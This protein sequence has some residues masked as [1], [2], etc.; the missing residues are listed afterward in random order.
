MLCIYHKNCAD[1]FGAAWAV[2]QAIS[3]AEF[4]AASHGTEPPDVTD[5]EVL[6][7]DFCYKRNVILEMAKK[8]KSITI[9]DHH[10]SAMNELIDLPENVIT[11]FDMEHSGAMLAWNFFFP[12]KEPPMLLRHIEDRDLWKFSLPNTKEI[13]TA[14]FAY[15]YD[16]DEWDIL[17]RR[18]LD[19]LVHEGIILERKH[20]KDIIE[21]LESTT[22]IMTIDGYRVKI[23]NL[24]YTMASEAGHILAKGNPFGGT[25]YDMPT[26]RAFSLRSTDEGV[27]VAKI[28]ELYGGGGH[29]NASGF[30]ISYKK[31]AEFEV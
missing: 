5:Q 29:R 16:F 6:M 27:D 3:D 18:S 19:G 12:K 26:V 25:Y 22:R 4:F 21:L 30:K 17:I 23:A 14:L 24:P 13:Q 28:A 15:P 9:I 1:G 8:A 31:A 2:R 10:V 20:N 11:K 7:V